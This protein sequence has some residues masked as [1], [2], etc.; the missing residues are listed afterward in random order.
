MQVLKVSTFMAFS[1][2]SAAYIVSLSR[3]A[4]AQ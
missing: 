3:R 1:L 2:Q 4:Q